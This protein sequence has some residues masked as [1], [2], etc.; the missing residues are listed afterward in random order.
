MKSMRKRFSGTVFLAGFFIYT[1]LCP[2]AYA[3]LDPGSGSYF[4]QILLSLLLAVPF[5]LK[6]VWNIGLELIRKIFKKKP[7]SGGK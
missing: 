5:F 1:Y 4:Y 6:Y 3:Y 7:D 2:P